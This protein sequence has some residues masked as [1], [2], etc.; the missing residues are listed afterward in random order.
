MFE[1]E[2][3]KKLPKTSTQEKWKKR[4]SWLLFT[5]DGMKCELC[6]KWEDS[7]KCCKN[8][9]RAFL[10]GSANYKSSAVSEHEETDQHL[11]S[12]ESQE[13]YENQLAGVSRKQKKTTQSSY[14]LHIKARL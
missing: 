13:D 11:K 4:H 14:K 5:R 1:N 2:P 6:V 8:F 12:I 7:I 9:Q 10:D 3:P